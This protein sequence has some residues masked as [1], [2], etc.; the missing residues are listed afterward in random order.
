MPECVVCFDETGPF[1]TENYCPN[2]G[3][4]R[5]QICVECRDKIQQI[6]GG[7]PI[8]VYREELR[9]KPPCF[10]CGLRLPQADKRHIVVRVGDNNTT[11]QVTERGGRSQIPLLDLWRSE[12]SLCGI[13]WRILEGTFIITPLVLLTMFYAKCIDYLT[14]YND[15][16]P[17]KEWDDF[18][19]DNMGYYWLGLILGLFTYIVI[20][21]ISVICSES[22]N[23]NSRVSP[24]NT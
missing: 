2:I 20:I 24:R 14:C 13:A 23:N 3:V 5:H 19:I 21:F 7:H 12:E 6:N 1:T 16:K 10:G 15:D 17:M 8:P 4:D 9:D 22:R 18:K 11:S